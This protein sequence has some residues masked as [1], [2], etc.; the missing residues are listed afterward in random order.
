M[1]NKYQEDELGPIQVKVFDG[2]KES[3]E[4]AIRKF[5][6]MVKKEGIMQEY[7]WKRQFRNK[8]E[9]KPKYFN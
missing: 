5:N 6:R 9:K 3:L 4:R 2:S 7:M 8:R 1:S